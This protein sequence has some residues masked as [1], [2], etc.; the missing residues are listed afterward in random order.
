MYRWIRNLHLILGVF[1]SLPLILYAVSAVQM[2]H[3]K[4]LPFTSVKSQRTFEMPASAFRD[5][6]ALRKRLVESYGLTG[7]LQESDVTSDRIRLTLFRPGVVHEVRYARQTGQT[8]VKTRVNGV[9]GIMNRLHHLAGVTH[10]DRA[11]N[12]WGWLLGA[13]SIA[14]LAIGAS[15]I[16]LWFKLHAERVIGVVLLAVSLGFSLTLIVLLRHP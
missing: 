14:L 1:A 6:S 9:V 8:V 3:D 2:A 7:E 13:V 16:Y 10:E 12:A 4:W 5:A 15:G 11:F